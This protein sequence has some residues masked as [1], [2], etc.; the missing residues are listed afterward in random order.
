MQ[1]F[2]IDRREQSAL[3]Q[4][5]AAT[6]TFQKRLPF[7]R[8]LRLRIHD[9][10]LV[11]FRVALVLLVVEPPLIHWN[12]Y[13]GLI[14]AVIASCVIV[15]CPSVVNSRPPSDE[16]SKMFPTDASGSPIPV[17]ITLDSKGVVY[18]QDFGYLRYENGSM[19]FEGMSCMFSFDN[20]IGSVETRQSRL[21]RFL[22]RWGLRDLRSVRIQ[23]QNG[24][25][26]KRLT[27]SALDSGK[28]FDRPIND[29]REIIQ[30]WSDH[31]V[32]ENSASMTPPIVM[33]PFALPA[34]RQ[35]LAV[36]IGLFAASLSCFV[37]LAV[38]RWLFG[39]FLGCVI[40]FGFLAAGLRAV[41][42]AARDCIVLAKNRN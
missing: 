13:M 9:G 38:E 24:D 42:V 19:F 32:P 6:W 10:N 26:R 29:V 37:G 35:R 12:S 5:P 30:R 28:K 41:I 14:V 2:E 7:F 17:R 20:R 16:L 27:I 33:S 8:Q 18:G 21:S 22:L 1:E 25:V 40:G 31:V 3:P 36:G 23:F 4:F 15:V 11:I 34:A 39:H